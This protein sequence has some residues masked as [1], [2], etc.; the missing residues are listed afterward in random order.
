MKQTFYLH[1]YIKGDVV[2]SVES[3]LR[4]LK[5]IGTIELDVTPIR[6]E[7]EKEFRPT[8]EINRMGAVTIASILPPE[9]YDVKVSYK[10]KE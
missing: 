6:K 8:L 4:E 2:L 9:A 5:P 1:K 7:V 3:Q 10:I